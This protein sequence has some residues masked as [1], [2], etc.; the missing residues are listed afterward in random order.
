M[1]GI[2]VCQ[3][4]DNITVPVK[5]ENENNEKSFKVNLKSKLWCPGLFQKT[6]KTH[7]PE[8]LQYLL[9]IVSL[10]CFT[11]IKE[12]YSPKPHQQIP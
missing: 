10:V 9:R 11:R 7:Y 2:P 3:G 1:N 5:I 12:T 6:N 4:V 8:H